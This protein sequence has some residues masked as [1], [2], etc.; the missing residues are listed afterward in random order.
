[1]SSHLWHII[2]NFIICFQK[3]QIWKMGKLFRELRKDKFPITGPCLDQLTKAKYSSVDVSNKNLLTNVSIYTKHYHKTIYFSTFLDYT[4]RPYNISW[5][6]RSWLLMYEKNKRIVNERLR[7]HTIKT[8][9][10]TV[11]KYDFSRRQCIGSRIR[12]IVLLNLM[13]ITMQLKT[14]LTRISRFRWESIFYWTFSLVTKT[15]FRTLRLYEFP[16]YIACMEWLKIFL[17]ESL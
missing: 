14:L 9:S 4:Q 6:I 1:M 17:H 5:L 10:L 16:M 13:K 7:T 8:E 15:M 11:H 12:R 2:I 3:H